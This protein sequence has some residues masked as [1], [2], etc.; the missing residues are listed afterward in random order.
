MITYMNNALEAPQVYVT[1]NDDNDDLNVPITESEIHTC[2][3]KNKNGKSS[4]CDE[5]YPEIIKYAHDELILM[6][7]TFDQV[8]HGFGKSGT[9][10]NNAK[11]L[12]CHPNS[13]LENQSL[14]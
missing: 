14:C 12:T 1:M 5:I 9:S 3:K 4:G 7:T 2:V 13:L 8:H 11:C 6:I 10:E